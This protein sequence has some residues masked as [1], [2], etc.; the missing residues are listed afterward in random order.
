MAVRCSPLSAGLRFLPR[1]KFRPRAGRHVLEHA[2]QVAV[3]GM[4][5]EEGRGVKAFSAGM[6]GMRNQLHLC[7]QI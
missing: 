2:L 3:L 4:L 1:S 6:A 5:P 7:G